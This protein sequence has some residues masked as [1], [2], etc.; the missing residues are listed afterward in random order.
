MPDAFLGRLMS[1]VERWRATGATL[2]F[3]E[4]AERPTLKYWSE[5]IA[6]RRI[7]A[8]EEGARANCR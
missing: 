4:P 2:G 3:A 1:L 6:T 8:A 7:A 5:L